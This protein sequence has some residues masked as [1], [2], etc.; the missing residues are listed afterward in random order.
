MILLAA[1]LGLLAAEI[2]VAPADLENRKDLVNQTI[3]VDGRVKGTFQFHKNKGFDEFH[4]QKSPVTFRLPA[5][6]TFNAPPRAPV[7]RATGIVKQVGRHRVV[8]VTKLEIQPTDIDRF[9]RA[10]RAL[11]NDDATSREGWSE[12]ARRRAAEY[13]DDALAARAAE[14]AADAIAIEAARPGADRVA[15]AEK[16][17]SRHVA[18]PFPAALAHQGFRKSLDAVATV[19]EAKALVKQIASFFP[20]ANTPVPETDLAAA[21]PGYQ[22]EPESFYQDALPDVR[23]ALDRRLYTDARA[24]ELILSARAM[25]KA[26][27]T[28]VAAAR[29][30]LPDRPDVQAQLRGMAL[31]TADVST[32]RQ[33]EVLEYAKIYRDQGKPDEAKSLLRRWLDDQ[34]TRLLTPTDAEY[35]VTLAE[36]YDSMLGDRASAEALLRE[37]WTIDPL[38]KTTSDMFRRLGYRQVDGEWRAAA[39]TTSQD[40]SP[41]ADGR[42]HRDPAGDLLKGLT[43]KEVQNLQ[44]RPQRIAR[45]VTQGQYREQWIY[46]SNRKTQYI[47]FLQRPDMPD[48]I[49]VSHETLD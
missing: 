17:R 46:Q 8:D 26:S 5:D 30:E 3:V 24:K 18:E 6:L 29:D 15:L 39:S 32:L 28:A 4:L 44:G 43:R 23:R 10:V 12:W 11:R 35:R 47:N 21:L 49:V 25:P 42:P 2:E 41:S 31:T 22:A 36:A 19:D 33:S 40:S 38:S 20:Q 48:A 37:A 34:R 14:V 1:L 7:V 13:Q 27:M 45:C 9:N 16:A